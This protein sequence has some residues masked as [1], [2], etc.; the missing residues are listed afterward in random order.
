MQS[1]VNDRDATTLWRR[2]VNGSDISAESLAE[3][4]VLLDRLSPESPLRIRFAAELGELHK[5]RQ[6]KQAKIK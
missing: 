4:Q 2:L 5:L 1:V 6:K 3:A